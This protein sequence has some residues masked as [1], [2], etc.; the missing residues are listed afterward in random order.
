MSWFGSGALFESKFNR[1]VRTA[2]WLTVQRGSRAR[3]LHSS[4][5]KD[6]W[7]VH[8]RNAPN[9]LSLLMAVQ[10]MDQTRTG[11]KLIPPEMRTEELLGLLRQLS[12][13][14]A[15]LPANADTRLVLPCN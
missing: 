2:V 11:L 6:G 5:L 10:S 13:R 14:G 7:K 4:W 15:A 1:P 9:V 8:S 12:S 3:Q